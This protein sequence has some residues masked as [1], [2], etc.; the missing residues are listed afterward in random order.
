M[1]TSEASKKHTKFILLS[2]YFILHTKKNKP[3]K[4]KQS[5]NVKLKKF[6]FRGKNFFYKK[7]FSPKPPFQK[8][9]NK[10]NSRA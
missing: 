7:S 9:F 5:V 1:L 3:I 6:F 2:L 4:G 8:N 10:K